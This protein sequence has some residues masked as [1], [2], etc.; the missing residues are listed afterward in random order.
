MGK[1][2]PGVRRKSMQKNGLWPP[3]E[4]TEQDE[5]A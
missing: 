3:E 1:M 5:T 4:W 2:N